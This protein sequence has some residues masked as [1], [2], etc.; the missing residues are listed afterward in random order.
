VAHPSDR[1]AVDARVV[2]AMLDRAET[3]LRV[4]GADASAAL[5]RSHTSDFRTV[6]WYGSPPPGWEL[7]IDAEVTRAEVPP[8]LAARY[9]GDAF[10][11]RWTRAES[12][13]KL[14]QLPILLWLRRHGLRVPAH[15]PAVWRTLTL[16]DLT[17]SVACLPATA[18][19][20]V[21]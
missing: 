19:R 10:W 7:A 13:S 2:R 6:G 20:G 4:A 21:R 18:S 9:G 3:R 1:A 5:T 15:V 17:V 11:A 8:A 14:L 16:A 12:L